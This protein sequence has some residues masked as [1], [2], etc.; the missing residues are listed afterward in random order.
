[1]G[2]VSFEENRL[3]QQEIEVRALIAIKDCPVVGLEAQKKLRQI[4]F[5]E[6]LTEEI[7]LKQERL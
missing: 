4:A 3:R 5:P 2:V 6:K 7:N 1:M